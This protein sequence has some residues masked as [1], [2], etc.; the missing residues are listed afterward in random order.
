MNI[1]TAG[2]VLHSTKYS[3]TSLIVKI[4]TEVQG[5]Q[6]FIIKGAFGK[7]SRVKAALF[8][9]MALVNITYN[10]HGGEKLKFL[11]DIVRRS[12]TADMGFDPVKSSILL[13]YNELIYKLLFDTGP[14]TVLFHFLEDEIIKVSETETIP[15]ELPLIFLI[16]LSV[17]LGFFPENNYSDKTPYFSLTE[18]RFQPWQI[19]EQSE[20]PEAES[21]YLAHLL[22]DENTPVPDRQTRNNLL[23]YLIKY[24]K[25]HN[26]QLKN[27]ESVE[28]LATILHGNS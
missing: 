11:K 14:D 18:C 19:D 10:D 6:S 24:F 17:I 22:R 27:V 21:L 23:R 25:I 28:I 13:F 26:E 2:I 4:F 16:R 20:L 8:S 15:A 7:K 1:T 9:P 3:D 5:T 12:T